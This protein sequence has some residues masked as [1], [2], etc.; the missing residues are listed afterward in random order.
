[1]KKDEHMASRS[2]QSKKGK[3]SSV[4]NQQ[5]LLKRIGA[6]IRAERKR[7][8]LSLEALAKKV[9][10]SKMTLH[11]IETGATAPSIVNLA[12]I[13]FHLKKPIES[14][15]KEGEPKVVVIREKELNGIMDPES[16]IKILAPRG[17]ISDRIT[18]T[19]AELDTGLVIHPHT[20][21]G[22]E[23]A[24]LT[25]GRAV[26]TVGNKKY[27]LRAGDSIFYD[28]HFPHSIE[29]KQKIHYIGLFLSD[30]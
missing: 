8:G 28:A 5:E 6:K 2:K 18:I 20:N 19:S 14:L 13:S 21:K 17:L 1:M 7:L 23:W 11:R 9:G 16:G 26:V 29:I 30:G 10:I 24:Y 22:F 15:I 4:P 27:E 12:E 25:K 3:K